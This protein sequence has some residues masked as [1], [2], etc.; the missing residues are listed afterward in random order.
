MRGRKKCEKGEVL[1]I[2]GKLP[3]NLSPALSLFF[4]RLFPLP[5]SCTFLPFLF[6]VVLETRKGKERFYRWRGIRKNR[7]AG[8]RKTARGRGRGS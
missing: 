5:R 2:G 4:K 6:P 8:T 3:R 1:G 7:L